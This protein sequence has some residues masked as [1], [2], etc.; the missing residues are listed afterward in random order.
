MGSGAWVR[1]NICN[2]MT[3]ERATTTKIGAGVLRCVH[4]L[5]KIYNSTDLS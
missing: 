1:E 5:S 2:F 3:K 4:V